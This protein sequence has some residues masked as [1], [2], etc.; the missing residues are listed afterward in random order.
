MPLFE[1]EKDSFFVGWIC[2]NPRVFPTPRNDGLLPGSAGSLPDV[3]QTDEGRDQ[4]GFGDDLKGVLQNDC[5]VATV[6][7]PL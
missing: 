7:W 1:G 5:N 4:G 3:T 2:I 6:F